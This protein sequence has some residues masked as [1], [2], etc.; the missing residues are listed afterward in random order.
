MQRILVDLTEETIKD[1]EDLAKKRQVSR[2]ELIRI[3]ADNFIK[4]ERLHTSANALAEV[5]G[6]WKEEPMTDEELTSLRDEWGSR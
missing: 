3:A 4:S 6:L 5:F 2:A 1:L